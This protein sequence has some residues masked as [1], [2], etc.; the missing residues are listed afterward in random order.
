MIHNQRE[1]NKVYTIAYT[2][3]AQYTVIINKKNYF[4]GYPF[5]RDIKA[6][7]ISI[8]NPNAN[9]LNAGYLS[10]S[11]IKNNIVLFNTPLT[12]LYL[13]DDYPSAKLTLVNIDGIDLLNSYWIYTGSSPFSTTAVTTLF[14]LSFYY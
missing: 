14:T 10:I 12:N 1:F 9:V 8:N 2:I 7:A 5:L 4:T 3:P 6:K 11:D 13:G